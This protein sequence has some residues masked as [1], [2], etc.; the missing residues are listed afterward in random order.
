M[1][2]QG[3]HLCDAGCEAITL[4]NSQWHTNFLSY[5]RL[6]LARKVMTIWW[7]AQKFSR[8][9]G[10]HEHHN[11]LCCINR[12]RVKKRQQLKIAPNST[13]CEAHVLDNGSWDAAPITTQNAC[14]LCVIIVNFTHE[15]T[16]YDADVTTIESLFKS[17]NYIVVGGTKC[18]EW[19]NLNASKMRAQLQNLVNDVNHWNNADYG[20]LVVFVITSHGKLAQPPVSTD[21]NGI[22][23]TDILSLFNDTSCLRT[24]PKLLVMA[25]CKG[26]ETQTDHVTNW[27][28][29]TS[30][31]SA[32]ALNTIVFESSNLAHKSFMLPD[33]GSWLI[34]T[35]VETFRANYESQQVRDMLCDVNAQIRESFQ[36]DFERTQTSSSYSLPGWTS[37]QSS[38]FYLT[39]RN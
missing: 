3:L 9:D 24:N 34:Q 25:N 7:N 28:L 26:S 16:G 39:D 4:S 29:D 38:L 23:P 22:S 21:T 13:N 18:D 11:K 30:F 8:G 35:M 12:G 2:I 36:G 37:T 15:L 32:A 14:G 17:L 31:A 6:Q 20:R 33:K 27:S 5:N 1:N 10:V 19:R